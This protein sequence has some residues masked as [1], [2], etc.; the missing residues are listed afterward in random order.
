MGVRRPD[1]F[2]RFEAWANRMRRF[3]LTATMLAIV[4]VTIWTVIKTWLDLSP[5]PATTLQLAETRKDLDEAQ[6]KLLDLGREQETFQKT[7]SNI[8]ASTRQYATLTPADRQTLNQLVEGERDVSQRL[9]ALEDALRLDAA[10]SLAVPL[11]R[12]DVD[13]LQ[14]KSKS[15][16]LLIQNELGRLFSLAQW[17]MGAIVT[18]ALAVVS[19][20]LSSRKKEGDSNRASS[21]AEE[22]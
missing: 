14:D 11:I 6:K 3:L 8:Q 7:L 2:D 4:A 16:L 15:D 1:F 10:K 22:K 17:F 5:Q 21:K 20:I 12:K 13:A 19:L 18:I 9:K